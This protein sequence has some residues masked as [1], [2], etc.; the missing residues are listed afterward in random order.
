MRSLLVAVLLLA[1][2][3]ASAACPPLLD[4]K[5]PT[6]TED[7]ASLCR[8]EGKVLLVVN[9]ASQCGYT[10]QYRRAGETL[11]PLQGQGSG[12]RRVSLQR[13]RRA[14]TRFKPGDRAVLR[15]EL[16][17]LVPDVREIRGRERSCQSVLRAACARIEQPPTVELPQV[18][19]RPQGRESARVRHEGRP[20]RSE[21]GERG[22]TVIGGAVRGPSALTLVQSDESGLTSASLSLAGSDESTSRRPSVSFAPTASPRRAAHRQEG[23][24]VYECAVPGAPL[25]EGVAG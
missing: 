18:S 13:F 25:T 3:A 22:R 19:R 15:V 10:P 16:W 21:V 12:R 7:A 9:T 6:L 17:R 11:S 14:G 23:V 8:F 24:L 2:S 20:Q 1:S 4:V 5:L